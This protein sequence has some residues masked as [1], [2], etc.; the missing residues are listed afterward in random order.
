[1]A[2]LAERVGR[3]NFLQTF[4]IALELPSSFL[5]IRYSPTKSLTKPSVTE[6]TLI[7]DYWPPQPRRR[8]V[9]FGRRVEK[10]E[11]HKQPTFLISFATKIFLM[12]TLRQKKFIFDA[13][14]STCFAV[15]LRNFELRMKYGARVL[16]TRAAFQ[17]HSESFSTF[18]SSKGLKPAL[19]FVDV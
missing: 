16:R 4:T 5:S 18:Y 12:A 14:K 3:E 10:L 19:F 13:K 15:F 9:E 1:M 17:P 8:C 2:F 11:S 6:S 7:F